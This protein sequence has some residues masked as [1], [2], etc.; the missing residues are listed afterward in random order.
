M[1]SGQ[2]KLE[3]RMSEEGIAY[4]KQILIETH[5]GCNLRCKGCFV[6]DGEGGDFPL[7]MWK[8]AVDQNTWDGTMIPYMYGE[9]M[10]WKHLYEGTKY[11]LDK[12]QRYYIA[13]NGTI[14]NDEFFNLIC[15]DNRAYQIIFSIDG[16]PEEGYKALE[17]C[18][19]PS[20]RAVVLRNIRRFAELKKQKGDKINIAVK[21]IK[22]GQ[23]YQELEDFVYYWLVKEGYVDYVAIGDLFTNENDESMRHYKC[24]YMDD[25]YM[26]IRNDGKVVP[27]M[28]NQKV[29][30]GYFDL[31]NFLETPNLLKLYNSDM[32]NWLRWKQ[33]IGDFP[34]PCITCSNPYNG[35]GFDGTL[36]FQN[37][38]YKG[39][40]MSYHQDYY[41][42]FFSL[43]KE[44]KG[45]QYENT[46]TDS[47]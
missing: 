47:D 38:E 5:K 46:K 24:W 9:P 13:T 28:Y 40:E 33:K 32:F 21:A 35:Y 25:F 41:N 29:V 26:L 36:R 12:G 15:S 20:K 27:C 7:E 42:Q 19:P 30:D 17:L 39:I 1:G 31:G 3:E 10:L 43:K 22:R 11:V 45:I 23:D 2:E 6:K 44:R 14:W 4:P 37:K 8:K 16:I 34:G 18:R